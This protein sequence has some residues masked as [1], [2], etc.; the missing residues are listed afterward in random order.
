[1]YV[2]SSLKLSG[3]FFYLGNKEKI[4]SLAFFSYKTIFEVIILY[5]EYR[6]FIFP[7]INIQFNISLIQVTLLVDVGVWKSYDVF[8]TIKSNI[9]FEF[10]SEVV[11]CYLVRLQM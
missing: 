2:A 5:Q 3:A 9:I 1:M 4:S 6:R 8:N 10:Q 11:R 7:F